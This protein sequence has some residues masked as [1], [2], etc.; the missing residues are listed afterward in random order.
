MCGTIWP[1][2]CHRWLRRAVWSG[3]PAQHGG[4]GRGVSPPHKTSSPRLLD[5][6]RGGTTACGMRSALIGLRQPGTCHAWH[7]KPAI[8]RR[9]SSLTTGHWPPRSQA[10]RGSPSCHSTRFREC[11]ARP[12]RRGSEWPV[13][14][15][16]R[17]TYQTGLVHDQARWHSHA[18]PG[19]R[20]LTTYGPG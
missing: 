9:Q 10:R 1:S 14:F 16:G 4:K 20:W 5:C 13:A 19:S 2:G 6:S 8:P 18:C 7:W 3:Q 12:G 11:S 17:F 15:V